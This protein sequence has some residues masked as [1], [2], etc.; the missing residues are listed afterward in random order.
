MTY[1][2]P[3]F[4]IILPYW[5]KNKKKL[6]LYHLHTT[7][8]TLSDIFHCQLSPLSIASCAGWPE[9]VVVS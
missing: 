2:L 4:W 8:L 6:H 3:V 9:V 1:I 5:E 7:H